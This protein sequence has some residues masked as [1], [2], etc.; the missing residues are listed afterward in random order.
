MATTSGTS[1]QSRIAARRSST[2]A[3]IIRDAVEE[4]I[5]KGELTGGDRINESALAER[6]SVSRGPIREAC[7]SLEEAGLARNVANHGAYVRELSLEEAQHLYEVRS[8]LASEAGRLLVARG[9]DAAIRKLVAQVDEMD[10]LIE[11]N[12]AEAYYERNIA[13]HQSFMEGSGNAALVS[14]Y[15]ATVKQLHLVRRRGLVDP[16]RLAES[17]AEHRVIVEAAV[18]R[19]GQACADA[20]RAHVAAGWERKLRLL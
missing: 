13:F 3:S 16:G 14:V 18:A 4:M 17:N 2:L 11:K 8:A 10:R 12:D 20:V 1:A 6:F 19:D 9:S 5:V 7:R 15:M